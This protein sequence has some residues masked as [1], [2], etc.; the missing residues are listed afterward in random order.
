MSAFH[1]IGLAITE[2]HRLR[3]DF[4]CAAPDVPDWFER[5][6]QEVVT[7]KTTIR[8]GQ[9]FRY[10]EATIVYESPIEHLTRWRY[11]FA[12]AMLE[13]RAKP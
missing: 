9:P 8:D 4:A 2:I 3:D 12:D 10:P 7:V 5:R 13:E 11:Y 1:G 6:S